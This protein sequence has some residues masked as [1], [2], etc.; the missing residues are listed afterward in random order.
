MLQI[1]WRP[2]PVINETV[3]WEFDRRAELDIMETTMVVAPEAKPIGERLTQAPMPIKGVKV[4]CGSKTA[5][6]VS[7]IISEVSDVVQA[8]LIKCS[9]SLIFEYLG[10]TV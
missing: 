3:F 1:G 6:A 7:Y 2:V 9:W 4:P 10:S 5:S 8:N